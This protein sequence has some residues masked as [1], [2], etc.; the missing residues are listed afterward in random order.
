MNVPCAEGVNLRNSGRLVWTRVE[1]KGGEGEFSGEP[2]KLDLSAIFAEMDRNAVGK[3]KDNQ[4]PST[5]RPIA[6][7]EQTN[8][9]NVKAFGTRKI[10]LLKYICDQ[11]NCWCGSP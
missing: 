4:K 10:L 5:A 8:P 2:K 7:N 3:T 11:Q 9:D 6:L 1:E